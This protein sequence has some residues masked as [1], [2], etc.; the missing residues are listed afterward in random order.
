MRDY[1][2]ELD[3]LRE[4]MAQRREDQTVL[5]RLRLQEVDCRREVET[6]TARLGKEERD[7]EKLEK[8][9]ISSML[10]SLRGSK[11]EDIDRERAEACAARLRLREAERQLAQVREEILD[12]Q[13]RIAESK[14]CE[15]EYEALLREKE[16]ELR[17]TDPALA[18][19]LADLERR[20]LEWTARRKELR[21]AEEAGRQ[22]LFQLNGAL[23]HLEDAEGWGTWDVFGG[24]LVSDLMKYSRLDDAQ[25]QLTGVAS[26]L[27]RYRAELSD[28]ARTVE[29]NIKPD[30]FTQTM[31]IWFDNI[32]S[33]WAVLDR[34]R[35]SREQMQELKN[36]VRDIQNS[37]TWELETTEEKIKALW[38]E[39]DELVRKA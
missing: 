17:K 27:R 8:L 25:Q 20:E 9:T 30:D 2:R 36:R 38:T 5:E 31:D 37:L 19:K 15:A 13:R 21:E 18:E 34:I 26:A 32:F 14:N 1:Q 3:A 23:G 35:Q 33:D 29:A 22:V 12:R 24:G 6:R 11:D 39:R 16:A 10:A 7:V 28:V 4:R